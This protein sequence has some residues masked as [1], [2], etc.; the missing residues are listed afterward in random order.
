MADTFRL[1]A[2]ICMIIALIALIIAAILFFTLNIRKVIG[3]LSG[4][5]AKKYVKDMQKKSKNTVEALNYA[6]IANI[7]GQIINQKNSYKNTNNTNNTD[8]NYGTNNYIN[9]TEAIA[10]SKNEGLGNSGES[11]TA[12]LPNLHNK[13]AYEATA[14]LEDN[15]TT[16]LDNAALKT[17][18][19]EVYLD[20]VVKHTNE[21]I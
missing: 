13:E 18:G 14:M 11:I 12:K 3:D 5:T 6:N 19:F 21:K 20:I 16:V 9:R 17:N 8:I 7:N 2:I 4:S 10:N 15:A 1:I